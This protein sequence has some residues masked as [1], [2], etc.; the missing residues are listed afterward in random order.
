MKDGA[1]QM[2]SR[3]KK[4]FEWKR[5]SNLGSGCIC[6]SKTSEET[7]LSLPGL[8]TLNYHQLLAKVETFV[9]WGMVRRVCNIPKI[10]QLWRCIL[11]ILSSLHLEKLCFSKTWVWPEDVSTDESPRSVSYRSGSFLD[12]H[13]S[14]DYVEVSKLRVFDLGTRAFIEWVFLRLVIPQHISHCIK[15]HNEPLCWGIPHHQPPLR[16]PGGSFYSTSHPR[17]S[18]QTHT[19]ASSCCTFYWEQ[20]L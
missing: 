2:Q 9:C 19:T 7:S 4:H 12:F 10:L 5:I 16:P 20:V 3:N 14:L 18:S 15:A 8:G 11:C 17:A 1:R 13:S 6:Y